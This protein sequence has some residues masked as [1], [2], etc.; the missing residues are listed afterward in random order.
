MRKKN[1]I[2]IIP[3]VNTTY[4]YFFFGLV[5]YSCFSVTYIAFK[6]TNEDK[7]GSFKGGQSS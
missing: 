2:A 3:L 1:N 7:I 5:F 4:S 6:A